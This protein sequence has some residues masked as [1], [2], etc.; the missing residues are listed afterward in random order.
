MP[1]PEYVRER[2]ERDSETRRRE[3]E[4]Y[5]ERGMEKEREREGQLTSFTWACL[6]VY[7]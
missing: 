3:R 7:R 1:E 5:G 4:R 6:F 2:G